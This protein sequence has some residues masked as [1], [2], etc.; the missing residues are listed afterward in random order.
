VFGVDGF[1]SRVWGVGSGVWGLGL[2]TSGF[3]FRV[4][5]SG[6]RDCGRV[7]GLGCRVLESR[8]WGLK[9]R[10]QDRVLGVY[11]FAFRVQGF[12]SGVRGLRFVVWGLGFRGFGLRVQ[13]LWYRVQGSW[14]RVQGWEHAHVPLMARDGGDSCI[15]QLKAQGSSRTC[16]ESKEEED[17]GDRVGAPA[18]ERGMQRGVVV[19]HAQ[20]Q[21]GVRGQ[22]LQQL[23]RLVQVALH[24]VRVPHHPPEGRSEGVGAALRPP[25]ACR[26]PLCRALPPTAQYQRQNVI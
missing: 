23:V 14:Y 22:G 20:Q 17:G 4:S 6:F 19:P 21:P 7:Y 26:C 15:T 11:G 13:E 24:R 10:V 5:G 16:T 3:G 18:L 9:L 12:R 8:F 1:G 2:R 25:R